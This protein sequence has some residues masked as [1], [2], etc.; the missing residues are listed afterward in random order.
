MKN[1]RIS[2]VF[3]VSCVLLYNLSMEK[4]GFNSELEKTEV[5]E[6]LPVTDLIKDLEV[7]GDVF[8]NSKF[9]N[10]IRD[11]ILSGVQSLIIK[12]VEASGIPLEHPA[13]EDLGKISDEYTIHSESSNLAG[14]YFE[15]LIPKG[16]RKPRKKASH[17]S[18]IT[19][20]L[21]DDYSDVHSSLIEAMGSS[22]RKYRKTREEILE[23]SVF[24][25]ER[26]PYPGSI[27]ENIL[28]NGDIKQTLSRAVLHGGVN[29]IYEDVTNVIK[30]GEV[31]V[32]ESKLAIQ[33]IESG[34][35]FDL[36]PLLPFGYK[37][38]PGNLDYSGSSEERSVKDLKEV[39]E[40]KGSHSFYMNVG[41]KV[42]SYGSLVE[43]GGVLSLFH[44][45]AHAW[46]MEHLGELGRPSFEGGLKVFKII[47][48]GLSKI[49]DDPQSVIPEIELMMKDDNVGI[50]SISFSP[51]YEYAENTV[52]IGNYYHNVATELV[53][54]IFETEDRSLVDDLDMQLKEALKK[55]G[56]YTIKSKKLSQ[57]LDEYVADERDA[58]AHAL[59]TLRF[60]KRQGLNVEPELE[61]LDDF[62]SIIDPCLA[63]YRDVVVWETLNSGMG[64][65]FLTAKEPGNTTKFGIKK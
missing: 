54:K 7:K 57:F 38:I 35:T 53:K 43:K 9:F 64:N 65:R 21:S 31:N 4:F 46:Q 27:E 63:S 47:I 42:V 26:K 19:T 16:L 59:K 24:A 15:N 60:L 45:I 22:R 39:D 8:E 44:E 32:P 25:K 51:T 58:W 34:V 40:N 29:L 13:S 49:I 10:D 52:I 14:E 55:S 11:R 36:E 56:Y 1:H 6:S 5:P 33:N 50:E 17:H 18:P 48:S 12:A 23:E 2:V 62:K 30:P 3:C 20:K 37:F 41:R 61:S 28:N